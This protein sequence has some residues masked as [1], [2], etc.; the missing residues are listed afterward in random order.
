MG[1]MPLP[2]SLPCQ[3]D[4]GVM[5]LPPSPLPWAPTSA[6]QTTG[7][8]TALRGCP[9]RSA[10]HDRAARACLCG[11]LL[12]CRRP[13]RAPLPLAADAARGGLVRPSRLDRAGLVP[14]RGLCPR[15]GTRRP[16]RSRREVASGRVPSW[17]DMCPAAH[18]HHFEGHR[19]ARSAGL[20]FGSGAPADASI[21]AEPKPRRFDR[22]RAQNAMVNARRPRRPNAP[23]HVSQ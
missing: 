13:Q 4:D 12:A 22:G 17:R 8:G 1:L 3:A 10:A 16:A 5:P 6:R 15:R 14:T 11:V 2:P 7:P 9:P 19:A 23:C 18:V 21:G 20:P